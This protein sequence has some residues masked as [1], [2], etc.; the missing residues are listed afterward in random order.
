MKDYM[1]LF[2]GM[3]VGI[4]LLA[5]YI[6]VWGAL[7]RCHGAEVKRVAPDGVNTITL[8]VDDNGYVMGEKSTALYVPPKYIPQ[9]GEH[10]V[11][12]DFEYVLIAAQDWVRITNAVA[13][14]EAVAERRWANEH[15]TD[16]GRRAWHGALKE[17][18][19]SEDGRGM[20]YTY[21]DGF[22][23]T[24]EA[25]PGR[26]E[27]PAVER[28]RKAAARPQGAPTPKPKVNIP[29]RLKAKREAVAARPASKEVNAVFGPGG[30]V[31]KVEGGK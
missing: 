25:E 21:A 17:K 14:L 9:S 26:R 24:D 13:R 23:Y 18:R 19:Q 7:M 6:L 29:Q 16:A 31:L 27:S 12:A 20:V 22:T 2:G 4:A 1:H 28:V 5:A 11:I 3:I 8:E 10:C 30:K 15:K